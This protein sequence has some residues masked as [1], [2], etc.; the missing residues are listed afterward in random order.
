MRGAAKGGGGRRGMVRDGE[1]RGGAAEG[2]EG[3]GTV[4][5]VVR[6]VRGTAKDP[7]PA[8]GDGV[9]GGPG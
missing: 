1:G 7:A 9:R 4:V 8:S 5:R 3:G 6:V 2:G